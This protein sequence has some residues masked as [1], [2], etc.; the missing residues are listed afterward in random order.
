M[1][2]FLLFFAIAVAV[3]FSAVGDLDHTSDCF[4]C[5]RILI[6]ALSANSG[7]VSYEYKFDWACNRT[8]SFVKKRP[9]CNKIASEFLASTCLR[10]KFKVST[11]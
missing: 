8:N 7:G 10:D 3:A 5:R 9:I 6:A 2:A 11:Y 1:R 4:I